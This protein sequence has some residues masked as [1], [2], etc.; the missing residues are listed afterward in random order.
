M[1]SLNHVTDSV[2][3][4][5]AW[6][7]STCAYTVRSP[8][9]GSRTGS[10]VTQLACISALCTAQNKGHSL[11]QSAVGTSVYLKFTPV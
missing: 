6:R 4:V 5:T 7:W 8:A 11:I 10:L 2:R 9:I 1:P 3:S